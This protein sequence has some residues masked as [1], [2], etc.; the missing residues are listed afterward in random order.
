MLAF[1]NKGH[2]RDE[3]VRVA[4]LF[5]EEGLILNPTFVAFTPWT[6][7][8]GYQDL[9]SLLAEL[10]L[11]D[12]VAPIQLAIRLLIPAGSKLLELSEVRQMVGPFDEDALIYPWHHADPQVDQ[13]QAEIQALVGSAAAQ[14]EGRG[15]M[16]SQILESD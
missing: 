6:S 11:I 12:H 15:E 13:L 4:H 5:R 7:V 8:E 1:L 14:G 9:L 2:S 10:D 16:F 3:F